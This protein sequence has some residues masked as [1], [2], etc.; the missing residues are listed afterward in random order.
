MAYV[1]RET[2]YSDAMPILYLY[3]FNFGKLIK[4]E[5]Y[6]SLSTTQSSLKITYYPVGSIN[7]ILNNIKAE[8]INVN[9]IRLKN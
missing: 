2:L 1:T 5:Q 6:I 3:A 8:S 4:L 7:I 9:G